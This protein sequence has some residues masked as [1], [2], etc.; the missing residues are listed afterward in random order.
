MG[1]FSKLIN[2]T[3][4]NITE[5]LAGLNAFLRSWARETAKAPT[6]SEKGAPIFKWRDMIVKLT[7]LK[8]LLRE[9]PDVTG[10]GA[11]GG[12]RIYTRN[13]EFY[14]KADEYINRTILIAL[15][16][17]EM[18]EEQL[19]NTESRE[20][21]NALVKLLNEGGRELALAEDSGFQD[22]D[23]D[24]DEDEWDEDDDEYGW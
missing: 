9:N 21:Y 20:E 11:F 12:K 6:E 16:N 15:A 7:E 19:E 3:T 17:Y 1:F 10:T 2:P 14:T 22:E 23:W 8:K 4:E 18:F 5:E 13:A 24:E